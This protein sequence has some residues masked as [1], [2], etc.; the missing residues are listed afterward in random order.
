MAVLSSITL[1]SIQEIQSRVGRQVEN[2]SFI[3]VIGTH[4]NNEEFGEG[5]V[6]MKTAPVDTKRSFIWKALSA[7]GTDLG[8]VFYENVL[9]YVDNVSNVDLCRVKALMSMMRMLDIDYQVIEKINYYPIEIQSLIDILSINKKYLFNN[10]FI[11]QDF[12]E[13]L[14]ADGCI[15]EDPEG[16]TRP[17]SNDGEVSSAIEHYLYQDGQFNNYLSSVYNN[18]IYDMLDLD[19]EVNGIQIA[20]VRDKITEDDGYL[21]PKT[22]RYLKN[23]KQNN[24]SPFFDVAGIVDDIEL[25]KDSTSNYNGP[26][27]SMLLDEIE[28]RKSSPTDLSA[29]SNQTRYSYYKKQKVISYAKF[30]DNTFVE[31][32]KVLEMTKYDYDQSYFLT[33]DDQKNQPHVLVGIGSGA[34]TIS[35]LMVETVANTLVQITNYIGKLREL[36]RFQ[37]RKVYMKGTNNLLEYAANEFIIDY[38]DYLRRNVSENMISGIVSKL[39]A[40]NINDTIIQEYWD[41]TEYMNLSSDTSKY[42]YNSRKINKRYFDE[43]FKRDNDGKLYPYQAP[44]YFTNEEI[45]EFYLSALALKN[46]L[47]PAISSQ[48]YLQKQALLSSNFY[49]FLSVLF[50]IAA[51]PSFY[52]EEFHIFGTKLSNEII[53]RERN[54]DLI[55][56]SA[57]NDYFRDL[58]EKTGY[59]FS[60]G[61]EVVDQLDGFKR[62]TQDFL[63]VQYL[64]GVSATYDEYIPTIDEISVEFQTKKEELS[65][66]LHQTYDYYFCKSDNVY[67]YD[68]DGNYLFDFFVGN[69]NYLEDD[70]YITH[71][72]DAYAWINDDHCQ[73][74]PVLYA[75]ERLRQEYSNA[76]AEIHSQIVDY[77]TLSGFNDLNLEN[78]DEEMNSIKEFLNQ[79]I[80]DRNT[81]LQTALG[82][83]RTQASALKAAY[84]TLANTFSQVLAQTPDTSQG[85]YITYNQSKTGSY[86]KVEGGGKENK[87][88][89]FSQHFYKYVADGGQWY[90]A[91]SFKS[92]NQIADTDTLETKVNKLIG[93]ISECA[94]IFYGFVKNAS[95]AVVPKSYGTQTDT[96]KSILAD[97]KGLDA[98]FN[99]I[100]DQVQALYQLDEEKVAQ[101][102]HTSDSSAD[103]NQKI[104]ELVAFLGTQVSEVEF[105]KDLIIADYN[106][107]LVTLVNLSVAYLPSKSEYENLWTMFS[108]FFEDYQK[109][110]DYRVFTDRNLISIQNFTNAKDKKALQKINAWFDNA[111]S[112]YEALVNRFVNFCQSG[113][114]LY[115]GKRDYLYE[116]TGDVLEEC[117]VD[118]VEKLLLDVSAKTAD[119]LKKVEDDLDI[120]DSKIS[121]ITNGDNG[122]YRKYFHD[123]LGVFQ[124]DSE[125]EAALMRL[126]VSFMDLVAK[127]ID[128]LDYNK[129]KMFNS[130]KMLFQNYTGLSFVADDPYYNHKNQTHPSY[131]VHPFLWNFIEKNIVDS[132]LDSISQIVT[133][134]DVEELEGEAAQFSIDSYIGQFGQMIDVWRHGLPDLTGYRT[135][136]ETSN[137]LCRYTDVYSEVVDYDGAFYPPALV[138]FL[139]GNQE[140]AK[141]NKY[142]SHL[143][144][145]NDD[146]STMDNKLKNS[147]E[148]IEAVAA[149]AQKA[150]AYDIFKYQIDKFGNVYILFKQYEKEEVTEEEKLQKIGKMWIRLADNPIALPIEQAVMIDKSYKGIDLLQVCDFEILPCGAKMVLTYAD[151]EYGVLKTIP[152]Y[153][154]YQIH[155]SSGI[156]DLVILDS[157][158]QSQSIYQTRV[159]P[160]DLFNG[161]RSKDQATQFFKYVGCYSRDDTTVDV[162]YQLNNCELDLDGKVIDIGSDQNSP[163][164]IVNTIS[165]DKLYENQNTYVLSDVRGIV[166]PKQNP[167]YSFFID[168]NGTKYLELAYLTEQHTT[169]LSAYKHRVVDISTDTEGKIF[170]DP[171][172]KEMNSF[173][174][175]AQNIS[176]VKI[177]LTNPTIESTTSFNTNADLGYIPAYNGIADDKTLDLIDDIPSCYQAIELLGQSKNIDSL[178]D[179]VNTTPNPYLTKE[180]IYNN[181]F[182]GRVYEN[183]VGDLSDDQFDISKDNTLNIFSNKVLYPNM[184]PETD[185]SYLNGSFYW[186]IFLANDVSGYS[187]QDLQ[188]LKVFIYNTGTLG[189]NPYLIVDLSSAIAE[190]KEL[191]DNEWLSVRYDLTSSYET[192]GC[193]LDFHGQKI[194][195]SGSQNGV[196][197]IDTNYSNQI[198]NIKDFQY[199]YMESGAGGSAKMIQLKLV[200]DDVTVPSYIPQDSIKVALINQYDLSFFEWYHYLDPGVTYEEFKTALNKIEGTPISREDLLNLDLKQFSYLSDVQINGLRLFE[201]NKRMSFKV[202]EEDIFP[203]SSI[204]YYVPSLNIKYPYSF[205]Q[206]YNDT[207][208]AGF[209][210]DASSMVQVFTS[211]EVFSFELQDKQKLS[212]FGDID[213]NSNFDQVDECRVFE[214][215]LSTDANG[216][217]NS[218]KY[219]IEDPLFYQFAHFVSDKAQCSIE[220]S[221]TFYKDVRVGSDDKFS[222]YMQELGLDTLKSE[223]VVDGSYTTVKFNFESLTDEQKQQFI[224]DLKKFLRVYVSYKKDEDGISL[225]VNYQNY[226]NSPY[227]KL[228][229]GKAYVDVLD[230]TYA[231]VKPGESGQVNVVLQFKYYNDSD[232][233]GYKNVTMATY[234]I[235]NISDDKPKFVIKRMLEVTANVGQNEESKVVT[236]DAQKY[237]GSASQAEFEYAVRMKSS[238]SL[239]SDVI[240]SMIYPP[241]LLEVKQ[242]DKNYVT[243]QSDG[244]LQYKFDNTVRRQVVKFK[245]KAAMA[246]KL[247]KTRTMTLLDGKVEDGFELKLVNGFV[248]IVQ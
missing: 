239:S 29:Y 23:K 175:F 152:L 212:S 178:I 149:P 167:A 45:N 61:T 118:I 79:K 37:V 220:V 228:E 138:E 181:N 100:V 208:V 157:N 25:G 217:Q 46:T 80:T 31:K 117:L 176:I 19:F 86:A 90:D 132:A 10:K 8:Q 168:L 81:Y 232:L 106:Q 145:S 72:N 16:C 64:S 119:G 95:S 241:N 150:D 231:L 155:R 60:A 101:L 195:V 221:P 125:F 143:N 76:S 50:D 17:L 83:F 230:G 41:Q 242:Y 210:V 236:I 109:G 246:Q 165:Q 44:A 13:A 214:D 240:V 87:Y 6:E 160:Q 191:G 223:E 234:N 206:F 73:T 226:V 243:K 94:N 201:T 97:L 177:K 215:Y 39:S 93:R 11:K 89:Q 59:Q 171:V 185:V 34:S 134:I 108:N 67:C 130:S 218:T 38:I 190:S 122:L 68:E 216:M 110:V 140:V 103:I 126:T 244:W 114:H 169:Q 15:V 43:T 207:F 82:N 12:I 40:H 33:E 219:H 77:I 121:R 53:T 75:T 133:S 184:P 47:E 227:V 4:V 113:I 107:Y 98:S 124:K 194:V 78:L 142:Y 3:D 5:Y 187:E 71:L 120:L 1:S 146:L 248:K 56:V 213:I 42:A 136:Y 62:A 111:F 128:E 198:Y 199:K 245:T 26:E 192:T 70:Y 18:F 205:G 189:R 22:D 158:P 183:G 112:S 209:E 148:A 144:M 54:A 174:V 139:D 247:G 127:L 55:E 193:Q 159:I 84:D 104:I 20:K 156:G 9:N 200:V 66:C 186:S 180:D 188:N 164:I 30:V 36:L 63:S 105:A 170:A 161:T 52:D 179:M 182:F 211:G 137:H 115:D 129:S 2:F 28:Y 202:S 154:D 123:E 222:R 162:I 135:R 203:L 91:I 225:Y 49:E 233:V 172:N 35:S 58:I 173:D 99:S 92:S 238:S 57:I 74:W 27:L 65:I 141:L 96:L 197:Q 224:E 69:S 163:T 116:Y 235:Y 237:I 24:V 153:I 166:Y 14:S 21:G 229:N 85:W 204:N 51:D 131:Q 102:K 7:V 147:A 151:R 32:D 48:T 196:N 88:D